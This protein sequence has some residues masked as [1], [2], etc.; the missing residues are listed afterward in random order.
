[1][2]KEMENVGLDYNT[3]RGKLRMPE[4]GRNVQKMIE[5][6]KSLPE[7]EKRDEQARAVIKVMETL[8][9]QVHQQENWEQ[10][11]WDH[12]H[13]ISGFDI[14]VD[15]PYPAPEPEHLS[16][17]PMMIP[18]K[19]K[20]LK[21]THYGRNIESIIDL[22]AEQPDGDVKTAMIRSLA[23]YMRQQYLI[24]NKDSVADSTIFQDIEKLSDYRIK[25]PEGLQLT[26]IASN[27]VF[28]KPSLNPVKSGNGNQRQKNG[29]MRTRMRN[30]K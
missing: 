1:M 15:S 10:K 2:D 3:Q 20:P 5:Y 11:L 7:K 21:A 12:L 16:A 6:V 22:I 26:R 30:N 27:A 28:S 9:T 18:V 8:N 29:G 17:R 14:D 19:R 13:A 24:W 23:I 25:V 4:Y